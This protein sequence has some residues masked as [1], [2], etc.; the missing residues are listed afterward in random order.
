MHQADRINS[1]SAK[2]LITANVT[3][4]MIKL[5]SGILVR[6]L[7]HVQDHYPSHV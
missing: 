2:T 4:L 3:I 7:S 6:Y 1:E 5:T